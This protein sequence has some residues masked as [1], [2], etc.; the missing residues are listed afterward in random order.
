MET[1]ESVKEVI[2]ISQSEWDIL[3][4]RIPVVGRR[5]AAQFPHIRA[6][7]LGETLVVVAESVDGVTRANQIVDELF[8]SYKR[9]R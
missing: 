9:G 8:A 3:W 1:G 2:V 7:W 6:M 5:V 4:N